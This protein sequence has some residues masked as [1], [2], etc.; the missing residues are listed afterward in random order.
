MISPELPPPTKSPLARKE[1]GCVNLY[2]LVCLRG[3]ATH[4]PSSGYRQLVRERNDL[5]ESP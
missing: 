5:C 1:A 4:A 2:A 3:Q